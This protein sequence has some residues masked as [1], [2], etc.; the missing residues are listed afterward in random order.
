MQ[1]QAARIMRLGAGT[2]LTAALLAACAGAPP[3]AKPTAGRVLTPTV[4]TAELLEPTEAPKEE[5]TVVP[6][7]HGAAARPTEQPLPTPTRTGGSISL[8]TPSVTPPSA[9]LEPTRVPETLSRP[10]LSGKKVSL[11]TVASGLQ[12]PLYAVHAGDGRGEPLIW[13]V[14][15]CKAGGLSR[16]GGIGRS[17]IVAVTV[18][19][20]L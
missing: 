10:D 7:L 14:L 15:W 8:L 12:Q 18:S 2:L 11:R 6:R 16:E 17:L 1:V 20:P 3:Q 19:H 4:M 9:T 13:V 5:A